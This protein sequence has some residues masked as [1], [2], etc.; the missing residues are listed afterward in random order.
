MLSKSFIRI[1]GTAALLVILALSIASPA[2][3]F[4][5]RGGDTVTIPADE[6]V[7]DDLYV[8]G[9]TVVINGTIKGDLI[10]FAQ[11]I[12]IN[13]TVE[14]DLIAAGQAIIINGNVQDD[15]R[16]AG[17]AL[18]VGETATIGSDLIG[19]GASLETRKGSTIGQD[20]VFVGGQVL[21]AGDIARNADISTG[22]LELRGTVGGNLKA[23]VGDSDEASPGTYM[24]M[25]DTGVSIPNVKSGLTIDPAAKIGG[26]LEYTSAK[27]LTIPEGVVAGKIV[28]MEPKVD[29]DEDAP[30]PV[31]TAE[32]VMNTG[33]D[34]IRTIATLLLFGLLLIWLFPTFIKNAVERVKTAPLPSLGWGVIAYAAFFFALLVLIIT[35]IIGAIIFGVLTLG[36]V[37]GT[38]VVLGL[39][40]IFALILGFVLVTSFVAQI[41]ISM[42]G[43][44]LILARIKPELADNKY[45]PLVIGVLI[46][47]ILVA[48]PIFGSL[49]WWVV[50]LLGLGALWYLGYERLGKKPAA[51]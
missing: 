20:V 39:L 35:M 25:P 7:D 32:L 49:V 3:A 36:T 48:I 11:T 45:L 26:D 43:G 29:E 19:A 37:S 8:A 40:A 1:M 33:L 13:G 4:D 5:G 2:L 10:A 38:I 34:I 6:V 22:G 31:T 44:Q 14:G 27:Q 18:F 21:L 23:D 46:Y 16:I 30:K 28:Y 51:A 17:A 15:A 12:T 9:E 50:V 41:L 24:F 47:A 42:L